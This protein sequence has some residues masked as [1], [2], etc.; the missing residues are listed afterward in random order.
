MAN[1]ILNVRVNSEVKR[2]AEEIFEELGLTA[3]TAV[4]LFLRQVIR[5]GGI[6]FAVTLDVPNR[7]T[8]DA[9]EEGRLLARDPNA[10]GY[11]NM[12]DLQAALEV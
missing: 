7:E 6:P 8:A 2:E 10:V 11:R 4:N 3:T 9:I 5:V 12:E 1:S